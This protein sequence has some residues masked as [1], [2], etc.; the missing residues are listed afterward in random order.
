MWKWLIAVLALAGAIFGIIQSRKSVEPLP[1]PPLITEPVRSTYAIS[2]A[3]SGLVEPSSESIVIGVTDP[4]MVVHVFVQ[5]GQ[6]VKEGDKLFELDARVLKSQLLSAQAA[7]QSADAELKRISAFRRKEDEPPLRA[8]IAQAQASVLEASGAVTEARKA[9]T[10]QAVAIADL[11]DQLERLERTEKAEATPEE[12]TARVRF[13]LDSE[14]AHLETLTAVVPTAEAKVKTAQAA[15]AAA[16]ADLDIFLAG[17]W[18]PDIEKARA[19]VSEAQANVKRLESDIE[20]FTVRAPISATVLRVNLRVGEYAMATSPTADT[21][22]M[23][24]GV[25]DPL[26]IRANIDEFDAQRFKPGSPAEAFTK[27]GRRKRFELEFVRVDPFVI[28]KR[29]L[30]NSQREM[31]DTRV[32]EII[33]RVKDPNSTLYVGQQLDVFIESTD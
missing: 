29:S 21:A 25:I 9:L 33:Y 14:K 10:Q 27:G 3:G 7:V 16:Q 26:H 1:V 15:V 32:L 4:G 19:A 13:K 31:V 23:V 8:K 28:P 17:A 5:Q 11:K 2:I 12:Q 30:T 18:P 6:K 22:P 20:R 24:L